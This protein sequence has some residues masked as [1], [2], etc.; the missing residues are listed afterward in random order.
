MVGAVGFA[1]VACVADGA[2]R[3]RGIAHLRLQETDRLRALATELS[4]LG[5]VTAFQT[6]ANPCSKVL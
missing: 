5:A 3:L 4:A 1:A 6:G 2:S